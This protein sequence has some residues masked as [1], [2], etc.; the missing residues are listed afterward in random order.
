MLPSWHDS[1]SKTALVEFVSNVTR[2]GGSDYVPPAE[3]IAVFDNDGTLWTE[4][5][6]YFQLAFALD[7]VKAL[8]PLHP[9]WINSRPIKAALDGDLK[10]L[11]K[12]GES[13]LVELVMA[14]HAGMTT[15]EFQE[16]VKGWLSSARHP[17]LKRPYTE[18]VF[19]PMIDV[20]DYLRANRFKTFIVSG[21]GIEFIRTFSEEVYGIPPEQV[22]GSSI[23]TK[24]EMR[25]GKPALVRLPEVDFIDDNVGKPVGIN[26]YIGRRPIAA[27]GNSDGDLQM[28]HWTTGAGGGARF[29]LIVRH[30]DPEREFAYDRDTFFGRLDKA[31]DVAAQNGW[32][33]VDMKSDWKR[34]FALSDDA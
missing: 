6:M 16:I 2:Q 3:R 24:F 8:A 21:G 9:E 5:P 25:E 28:L 7:R 29:G 23:K 1:A 31:L 12:S 18:L 22:V 26:Q 33:V 32:T 34:I 4:Q 27:F 17:T 14:S 10:A 20:M 13:G 30:T 15:D 19:Q 11:V